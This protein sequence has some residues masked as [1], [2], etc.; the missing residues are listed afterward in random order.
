MS[1]EAALVPAAD[2]KL[3]IRRILGHTATLTLPT[4]YCESPFRYREYLERLRLYSL[5]AE[6][7]NKAQD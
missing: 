7:F 5:S 2:I 4:F 6:K 1:N 3:F